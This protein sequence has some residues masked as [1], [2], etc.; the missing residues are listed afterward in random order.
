MTRP[1]ANTGNAEGTVPVDRPACRPPMRSHASPPQPQGAPMEPSRRNAPRVRT[2]PPP[3]T[4][5]CSLAVPG[6]FAVQE[7]RRSPENVRHFTCR[8]L[9]SVK[10]VT[11]HGCRT[12]VDWL[13]ATR[14]RGG[15]ARSRTSPRCHGA[16]PPMPVS[17]GA[18]GNPM[19]H[20]GAVRD[21]F[22]SATESGGG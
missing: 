4:G 17:G 8:A 16:I 21:P 15:T 9:R 22:A 14:I 13:P 20:A 19:H 10:R 12:M 5:S 1:P 3:S 18:Q 2:R 11:N 6:P 7:Y